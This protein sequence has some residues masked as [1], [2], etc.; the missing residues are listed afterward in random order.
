MQAAWCKSFK[1]WRLF[2]RCWSNALVLEKERTQWPQLS[3]TPALVIWCFELCS[4]CCIKLSLD[5]FP[6]NRRLHFA[7][8]W[9]ALA[10]DICLSANGIFDPG[11]TLKERVGV[12]RI[13]YTGILVLHCQFL[14]TLGHV[15]S[16]N[17]RMFPILFIYDF[18]KKT[19]N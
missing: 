11:K 19:G 10:Q 8:V 3:G 5:S 16:E 9:T 2:S 13:S 4:K 17:L 6:M 12:R 15:F 1:W 18:T 14:R 7:Q